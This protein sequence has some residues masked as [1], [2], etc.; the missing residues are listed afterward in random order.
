MNNSFYAYSIL[1]TEGANVT[2]IDFRFG[3]SSPRLHLKYPFNSLSPKWLISVSCCFYSFSEK[4]LL[5]I[6]FFLS[7]QS[8]SLAFFKL[9]KNKISSYNR[10]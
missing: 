9:F 6:S 5:L 4:I 8:L 3:Y 1:L 2:S 10:V 7:S